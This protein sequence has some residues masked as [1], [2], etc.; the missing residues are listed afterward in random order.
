MWKGQQY[1]YSLASIL[2]TSVLS[3]KQSV[4]ISYLILIPQSGWLSVWKLEKDIVA[5]DLDNGK[6]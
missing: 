3:Q 6:T 2:L 1:T 4:K 5:S